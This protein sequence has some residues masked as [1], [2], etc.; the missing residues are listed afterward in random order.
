MR[1]LQVELQI[2]SNYSPWFLVVSGVCYATKWKRTRASATTTTTTT[3][4]T[5][6]TTTTC[7]IRIITPSTSPT[8]YILWYEP[9]QQHS[10]V[11]KQ[12]LYLLL[13]LLLFLMPITTSRNTNT[14][15]T[16][17]LTTT[18]TST[19]TTTTITTARL[20]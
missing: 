6:G 14:T 11:F 4:T 12:G 15:T 7:I 13:L 2:F 18:T 19:T 20:L 1:H 5:T 3:S 8:K 9:G 16:T 10:H 17:T